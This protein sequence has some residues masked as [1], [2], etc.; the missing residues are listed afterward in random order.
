MIV[1]GCE[2][3]ASGLF[4]SRSKVIGCSFKIGNPYRN[5]NTGESRL[6]ALS[7][8]NPRDERTMT[9]R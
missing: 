7:G 1:G 6:V 3:C 4:V 5:G 2:R 9:R 8:G